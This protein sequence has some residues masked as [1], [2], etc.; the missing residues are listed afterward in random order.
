MTLNPLR[1]PK[2]PIHKLGPEAEKELFKAFGQ[3]A[4]GFPR[5]AVL[6][7]AWNVILN[8]IRQD[9]EKRTRAENL[10]DEYAGKAKHN[11]LEYHYD[12]T[13]KRR[14]IFPF[15]QNVEVELA[16]FKTEFFKT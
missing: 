10:F 3:T 1:N 8:V 5:D 16:D 7:A 2:D 13:G 15:T 4:H 9:A 14:N 6:N 11:L 12:N